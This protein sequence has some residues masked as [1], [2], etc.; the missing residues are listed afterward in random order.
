VFDAR[1]EAL[2]RLGQAVAGDAVHGAEGGDDVRRLEPVMDR[3]GDQVEQPR[4]HFRVLDVE[5][6]SVRGG[7]PLDGKRD[8]HASPADGNDQPRP[9]RFELVV[10]GDRAEQAGR[11]QQ[12]LQRRREEPQGARHASAPQAE[13]QADGFRHG[14]ALRFHADR[15]VG[16]D[17]GLLASGLPAGGDQGGGVV[18]R[19][20]LKLRAGRWTS[21]AAKISGTFGAQFLFDSFGWRT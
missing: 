6:E 16:D 1:R 5:R 3:R 21:R 19:G 15:A 8:R 4:G 10:G 14:D 20:R 13:W 7:E 11:R 2:A 12:Q 17:P 9:R 18:R